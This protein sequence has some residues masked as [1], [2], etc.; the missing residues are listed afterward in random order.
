MWVFFNRLILP[1]LASLSFL[2]QTAVYNFGAGGK[3]REHCNSVGLSPTTYE[4]PRE[5]F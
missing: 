4:L 2:N 5:A 1:F 3:L